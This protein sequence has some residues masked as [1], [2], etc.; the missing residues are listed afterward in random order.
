MTERHDLPAV[1]FSDKSDCAY[2]TWRNHLSL[3]LWVFLFA[4]RA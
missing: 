2:V 4:P 3:F 1:A